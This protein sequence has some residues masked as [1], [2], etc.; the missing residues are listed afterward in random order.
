MKKNLLK[1][2]LDV[3]MTVTLALLYNSHV[4]SMAFHEIAGLGIFGLLVIHCLLNRKWVVAVTK[5]FL[6]KPLS[7][8]IRFGYGIDAL[9]LIT[10][11]TIITS[12]ICESQV[13]FPSGG[14][15][16]RLWRSVHHFSA[17]ISVVLVGI[18]L[19]LH[20]G[21]VKGMFKKAMHIHEK[22]ARPMSMAVLALVLAFGV[23]NMATG[24]FAG[25]LSAPFSAEDTNTYKPK[26]GENKS[27]YHNGGGSGAKEDEESNNGSGNEDK[28]TVVAENALSRILNTMAT[29]LSIIGVFAALTYYI[30]K[31]LSRRKKTKNDIDR[32]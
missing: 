5:Q 6:G 17:G 14:E 26:D 18:H 28:N 32:P 27:G 31:L 30:E 9:L 11:L 24:S 21:F 16:D 23:Y 15:K 10:F 19:G 7:A 20:W 1:I 29:Y 22:A 8:K 4:F 12:G 2:T 13:L 3:V 25:L